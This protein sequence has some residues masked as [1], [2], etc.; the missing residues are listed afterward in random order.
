M[1][2]NN[3]LHAAA[4]AGC[5]SKVRAL[6]EAGLDVNARRDADADTPLYIAACKGHNEV[7]QVLLEAGANID[8]A[9]GR[10]QSTPLYES[11]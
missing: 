7:V 3:A 9:S 1:V 8:Q 6:V 4:F 11:A 2:Y 5:P 10:A